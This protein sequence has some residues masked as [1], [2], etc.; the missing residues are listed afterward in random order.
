MDNKNIVDLKELSRQERIEK[1]DAAKVTLKKEF[2]GLDNIIDEIFNSVE[3]WYV[4]PEIIKRPVIVSLWGMTGTGKSSVTK[5]LIELLELDKRSLYI[6]CGK[7]ADERSREDDIVQSTCDLLGI[8]RDDASVANKDKEMGSETMVFVFDEFQ[9]AKTLDEGGSELP[10][11]ANIRCIWKIIDDGLMD[12]TDNYDYEFNKFLDFID[13]ISPIAKQNP[14]IKL[15][16]NIV[17]D[18]SEVKFILENIGYYVYSWRKIPSMDKFADKDAD[19]EYTPDILEEKIEEEEA[20]GVKDK[21]DPYRPLKIIPLEFVRVIGRRANQLGYTNSKELFDKLFEASTFGELYDLLRK[22]SIKMNTHSNLDCHKSLVFIVGNLDEAFRVESEINP[23]LDADVFKEITEHITISDIKKALKRRFRAEQVARIGNNIVKYPTLSSNNF[24]EIIKREVDRVIGNF[25]KEIDGIDVEVKPEILNLLY[26]EGVF[27]T[28]GVRP[29]Y[30]TIGSMFTPYL[31]KILINKKPEDKKVS[32]GLKNIENSENLNFMI[33]N[34]TIVLEFDDSRKVEYNYNL[35]LGSLRDPTKV[36]T[37]YINSVHESGHAIMMAATTGVPP[38]LIVSVSTN[39]GGFCCSYNSEKDREIDSRRD[40]DNNIKISLGGYEAEK[41]IFGTD[42]A[43]SCLMGSSSDISQAWDDLSVAA[44]K[45]G[46]F[47]PLLVTNYSTEKITP[48]D[49]Q[50]G[51]DSKTTMVKYN[52]E[53]YTLEDAM[54]AKWKD[55]EE[56]TYKYLL[57]EMKLIKKMALYLG[58]HG[59]MGKDKFMEFVEKYG[60]NL[61]LDQ[62]KKIKKDNDGSYYLSRLTDKE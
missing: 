58:E 14:N 51:F 32:I 39:G 57:V 45:C 49:I 1:L 33:S 20:P 15:K 7:E 42:N 40:V 21:D 28:Q 12:I 59:S 62:M 8:D 24:K 54:K 37:R 3:P 38:Q 4:T 52:S 53:S 50:D 10:S 11:R 6:D 2:V 61:T 41:L 16:D 27:P 17:N 26:R 22:I 30:T 18:P 5:R 23:D 56:E 48:G 34:T 36:S 25:K 13:D 46:Y 60:N 44:L 9:Y 35:Q 47:C 55:L 19:K 43:E 31:S 29:V